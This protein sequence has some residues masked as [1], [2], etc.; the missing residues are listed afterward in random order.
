MATRLLKGDE[1]IFLLVYGTLRRGAAGA[2]TEFI[3]SSRRARYR[4]LGTCPGRLYD[5]GPYPALVAAETPHDR[6]R[7]EIWEVDAPADRL[8][9]ELDAYEA[10]GQ[11]PPL[12]VRIS[13]PLTGD[14]GLAASGWVYRYAQ[15]LP[16]GARF[17]P[18]GDYLAAP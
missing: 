14:H 10:V 11:R 2:M 15:P 1:P 18:S 13:L 5:L 17:L 6:V 12:F 8:L 3:A 7:G 16:G 9:A 4:G